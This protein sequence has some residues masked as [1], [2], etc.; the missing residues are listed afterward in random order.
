MGENG[1]DESID[2][3]GG[4]GAAKKY[5]LAHKG[6]FK[7]KRRSRMEREMTCELSGLE[8]S[9]SSSL[10]LTVKPYQMH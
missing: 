3:V 9:I 2:L 10:H 4:A 7:S 8:L 5:I 6:A 1:K